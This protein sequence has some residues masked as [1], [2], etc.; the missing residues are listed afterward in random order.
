[1]KINYVF[2][3]AIVFLG[4]TCSSCNKDIKGCT[5]P[6]A[7]NYN[8]DA[9]IDDGFCFIKGCTNPKAENYNADATIDNGSCIIKGCIDKEAINFDA[10]ANKDDGTCKYPKDLFLGKYGGKLECMNAILKQFL[11]TQEVELII[12]EIS[13]EKK[14]VKVSL[15]TQ[16]PG[17]QP[18]V[19]DIE[20]K[21]FTY[22]FPETEIELPNLGKIKITNEGDFTVQ[23]DPNKLKGNIKI[24]IVSPLLTIEDECTII[25]VKK[26]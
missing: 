17:A 5:N 21:K 22:A 23:D 15:N 4:F 9:N 11:G 20:G 13:G 3:L 10:L 6:K 7:E 12:E 14:K 24:R 25:A 1:M 19:A 8:P 16:L 2:I 18:V 26:P